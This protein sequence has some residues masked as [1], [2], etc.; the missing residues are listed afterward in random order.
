MGAGVT[1]NEGW[2]RGSSNKRIVGVVGDST[3]VH[4]GITGL[5]NAAYNKAKGII[6]ILDNS[7]TAMTGG[8]QHPATGFNIRNEP[9]KKLI[10][11]DLCKSCGADYVDVVDPKNRSEFEG[12]VKKRIKQDAL[13]VIISRHPCKLLKR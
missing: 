11:E 5:I 12:L 7:T 2:R 13:S 1:F 4:S 6:I 8:Q 3:F 9:T 10:L